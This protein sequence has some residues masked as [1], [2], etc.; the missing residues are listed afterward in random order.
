ML[1]AVGHA[2]VRPVSPSAAASA[3]ASPLQPPETAS[4]PQLGKGFAAPRP[5][6]PTRQGHQRYTANFT[7]Q[8]KTGRDLL[9][10]RLTSLPRDSSGAA[11][12]LRMRGRTLTA[13]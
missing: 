8:W 13:G 11:C 10:A 4:S 12:P 1:I 6:D 3:R 9:G 5:P 7:E 2:R